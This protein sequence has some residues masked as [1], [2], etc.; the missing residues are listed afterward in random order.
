M[1][2]I[3]LICI[4]YLFFISVYSKYSNQTH[5]YLYVLFT[6]YAIFTNDIIIYFCVIST[7]FLV[8]FIF[9][10]P[11]FTIEPYYFNGLFI[12]LLL[13]CKNF[14]IEQKK[15]IYETVFNNS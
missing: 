7:I 6:K 1:T 3:Y 14:S 10:I 9:S 4:L 12:I 15:G 13:H 2:S 8:L 5:E 11:F